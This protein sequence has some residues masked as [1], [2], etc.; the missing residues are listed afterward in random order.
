M[1]DPLTDRLNKILPRLVA[2]DFLGGGGIGNEIAFYV[3]DYPPEDEIRVRDHIRSLLESISK[4]RPGLRVVHI[5]LF[6]FVLD[7]LKSRKYLDKALEMQRAKGDE[8]VKKALA[9]PLHPEK[10]APLFAEV[11]R[12]DLHDLVIVSG[13]GSVYPLMR[14]SSL[15]SNL[16]RVMG[17]TPLVLF[18]P[19]RY[20]QMTLKLFGKLGLSATFEGAGKLRKSEN[21]YRAFRLVP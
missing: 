15:L 18:Y 13:V 1:S 17:G 9:G 11:A 20:D 5:N 16:Q 14:T 8:A 12:P 21:Y 19:G 2:N 10:L 3:F 7:H 6:D 4:K